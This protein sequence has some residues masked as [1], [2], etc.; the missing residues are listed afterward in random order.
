MILIGSLFVSKFQ[1]N[2]FPTP[3]I[4]KPI[5]FWDSIQLPCKTYKIENNISN[6]ITLVTQQCY[7]DISQMGILKL[8]LILTNKIR[9]TTRSTLRAQTS[10]VFISR[11][12]KKSSPTWNGLAQNVT[13]CS[14]CPNH[15]QNFMKI[16]SVISVILQ[17]T[18]IPLKKVQHQWG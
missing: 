15:P 2:T 10:A 1:F 7:R 14:R 12:M 13:N 6:K 5:K 8:K 17:K 3:M 9:Y 11:G 16:Y 18:R 4:H